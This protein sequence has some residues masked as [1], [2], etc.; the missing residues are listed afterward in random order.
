MGHNKAGEN[1]KKRLKRKKKQDQI[2]KV[3]E[4]EEPVMRIYVAQRYNET[5]FL[6]IYEIGAIE[7]ILPKPMPYN[8]A[9]EFICNIGKEN[10]KTCER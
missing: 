3:Q 10:G 9:V 1:R 7:Y 6:K 4:S 2:K 8:K 5:V